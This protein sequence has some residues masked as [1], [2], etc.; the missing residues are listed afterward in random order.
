MSDTIGG[1]E[2]PATRYMTGPEAVAFIRKHY[3]NINLWTFYKRLRQGHI[4]AR[5]EPTGAYLIDVHDLISYYEGLPTNQ[6]T[7]EYDFTDREPAPS[8]SETTAAV[9]D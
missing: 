6:A 9:A 2:L 7:V 3:T 8:G 1:I 4:K 5:I